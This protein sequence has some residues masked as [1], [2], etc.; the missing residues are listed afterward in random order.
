MNVEGKN[1][2]CRVKNRLPTHLRRYVQNTG[3]SPSEI[4]S[5][6]TVFA[7][8]TTSRFSATFTAIN[9]S[10]TSPLTPCEGLPTTLLAS[11]RCPRWKVSGSGCLIIIV[12]Y[13]KPCP[14]SLSH[15]HIV[16]SFQQTSNAPPS[17]LP[18][19]VFPTCLAPLRP[20]LRASASRS[21]PPSRWPELSLTCSHPPV[22]ISI[23]ATKMSQVLN[24]RLPGS[25]RTF[26]STSALSSRPHCFLHV[27]FPPCL[28]L[29]DLPFPCC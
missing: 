29:R 5:L 4:S 21:S 23:G 22:N 28:F 20:T 15:A 17:H 27:L 7:T 26:S 3:A 9:T 12:L 11:S 16:P 18:S 14:S 2:N 24:A 1:K 19:S 13:T 10:T 25:F 8:T 6:T